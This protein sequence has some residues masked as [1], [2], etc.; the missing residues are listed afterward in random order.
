MEA[1]GVQFRQARDAQGVSLQQI[2]AKTKISVTVLEAVERGDFTRL[3]GGIFGRSI[4]RAYATEVGLAADSAV[5]S[6]VDELERS[7]RER[8][9]RGAVRPE[10][11]PDDERFL[12]RQRRAVFW[13]R[14]GL[15]S[16]V[17]AGL[18]GA[19]WALRGGLRSV[20]PA[21]PASGIGS[22]AA[23]QSVSPPVASPSLA[24][25]PDAVA[26]ASTTRDPAAAQAPVTATASALVVEFHLSDDCWIS[27]AIDGAKP[28]SR[29]Y[30]EGSRARFEGSR[31]I[32]FELGNAGVVTMSIGGKPARP[33][34]KRG[35]TLKLRITPDNAASW[36]ME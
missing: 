6:F 4:V 29:T 3:P 7:E 12:E 5:S 27:A 1:L 18:A 10:I 33:L 11:T 25:G 9:A 24:G 26:P 2:A 32:V 23:A 17:V 8:A 31:E 15:A 34:G 22:V 30:A 36:L 35:S 21:A 20:A 14:V 19:A 28:V 16:A 13:L